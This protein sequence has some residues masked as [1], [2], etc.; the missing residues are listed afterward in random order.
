MARIKSRADVTDG[1]CIVVTESRAKPRAAGSIVAMTIPEIAFEALEFKVVG[2]TPL[3]LNPFLDESQLKIL[4]AQQGD[5]KGKSKEKRDP[6]SEVEAILRARELENPVGGARY[7]VPAKCLADAMATAAMRFTKLSKKE[8]YGYITI[9]ALDGSHRVPFRS[10]RP[11]TV[12]AGQGRPTRNTVLLFWHP[13]FFPWE[14][15]FQCYFPPD[16][17]SPANVGNLVNLA[18]Q[19]IGIGSGRKESGLGQG[20]FRI[21]E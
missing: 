13:Q 12:R 11:H 10:P 17:I 6:N 9:T 16:F 7:W 21:R 14:L 8:I 18:G 1:G 20:M 5:K 3:E 19:M 4:R 2:L 15:E